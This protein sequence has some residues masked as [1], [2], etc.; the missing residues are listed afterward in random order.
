MIVVRNKEFSSKKEEKK[1]SDKKAAIGHGLGAV[2]N[3]AIATDLT[4][5]TLKTKSKLAAAGAGLGAA[6]AAYHAYKAGKHIESA[7][8]EKNAKKDQ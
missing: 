6:N 4:K 5:R 2:L 1:V 8:K 3:A 7:A